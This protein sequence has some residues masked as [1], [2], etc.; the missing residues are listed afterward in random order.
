MQARWPG[1]GA[2]EWSELADADQGAAGGGLLPLVTGEELVSWSLE[3]H[4]GT[5]AGAAAYGTVC[6]WPAEAFAVG[7]R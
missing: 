2:I 1:H 4:A 3:G 5:V 7:I 6:L